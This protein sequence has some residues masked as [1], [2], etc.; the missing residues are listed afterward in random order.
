MWLKRAFAAIGSWFGSWWV[1][2]LVGLGVLALGAGVGVAVAWTA[3]VP[4]IEAAEWRADYQKRLA[5][6]SREAVAEF[7]D[8]DERARELD[9]Q[10]RE[11]EEISEGLDQREAKLA[12]SEEKAAAKELTDGVHT[13]GKTVEAGVYNTS[14]S[15]RGC[16]YAWKDGTGA[17]ANIVDNNIV[18]SGPATVTLEDGQIFESKNCGIW[19]WE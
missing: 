15:G 10:A 6:E 5:E 13:V 7:G 19:T 18:E 11:L 1:H 3:A 17:D 2:V 14:V 8:L 12:D 16:Y 4:Q 9:E